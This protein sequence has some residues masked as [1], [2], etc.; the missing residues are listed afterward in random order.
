MSALSSLGVVWA[1]DDFVIADA[2]LVRFWSYRF[3][4]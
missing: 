1:G 3:A 4:A 2:R